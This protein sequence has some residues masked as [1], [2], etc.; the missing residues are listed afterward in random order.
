M[1]GM[2]LLPRDLRYPSTTGAGAFLAG[3][4][5]LYGFLLFLCAG[6]YLSIEARQLENE[7][8]MGLERMN[9]LMESLGEIEE[10]VPDAVQQ[11][12]EPAQAPGSAGESW[13]IHALLDGL[14][15]S[16]PSDVWLTT[17]TVSATSRSGIADVSAG[18]P[19]ERPELI[20]IE[21]LCETVASIGLILGAL[22]NSGHYRLVELENFYRQEDGDIAF[23]VLA[24]LSS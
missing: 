20:R 17:L 5:L 16:I 13:P 22:E 7:V 24:W 12:G 3:R 8:S 19:S 10:T 21:G 9:A 15:D 6:I 18:I 4:L 23:T 11:P 14:D 2:N 1:N